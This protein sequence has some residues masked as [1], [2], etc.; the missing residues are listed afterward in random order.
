MRQTS[1]NESALVA[2]AFPKK[3]SEDQPQTE[4]N[5]PGVLA[6]L[7]S[8]RAGNLAHCAWRADVRGRIR[9]IR[10]IEYV[11]REQPYLRPHPLVDMEILHRRKVEVDGLRPAQNID[12]GV[13]ESPDIH[14]IRADRRARRTAGDR[15]RFGIEKVGDRLAGG[16]LAARDPVRPR[17]E[18]RAR[19]KAVRVRRVKTGI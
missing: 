17:D 9:K 3:L 8:E 4:V 16:E 2:Y 18:A 7:L 15:E 12:A 1:P 6:D 19:A 5:L 11:G 13:A 10:V 14:R